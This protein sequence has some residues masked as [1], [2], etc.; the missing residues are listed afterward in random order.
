MQYLTKR[1]YNYNQKDTIEM[2]DRVTSNHQIRQRWDNENPN[3]HIPA[4]ALLSYDYN[5]Y[6]RTK[7]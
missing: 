7:S 3:A 2:T 5:L 4:A 1:N 6:K